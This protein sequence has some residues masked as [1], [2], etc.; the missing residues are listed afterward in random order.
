MKYLKIILALLVCSLIDHLSFAAETTPHGYDPDNFCS[1]GAKKRVEFL[2]NLTKSDADKI[3]ALKNNINELKA[4]KKI[5]DDLKSIR[6][7]YI[8]SFESISSAK[9]IAATI[10][11]EKA[12][13]IDKFKQ[14]L[15]TN[16][17]LNAIS[18]IAKDNGLGMS[19]PQT[20]DSLCDPLIHKDNSSLQ[21]CQRYGN[22]STS[23]MTEMI[24]QTLANFAEAMSQIPDKSSVAVD[25]NKILNSI[26][27]ELDPDAV[28]EVLSS[29]S[30][31]L[32]TMTENADS[33]AQ[34][35]KCIT[36]GIIFSNDSD[37]EKLIADPNKRK[38]L[39][40]LLGKEVINVQESFVQRMSTQATQ[41]T[42]DDDKFAQKMVSVKEQ[43][44]SQN[45]KDLSGL[46]HSFDNPLEN[47][48]ES[49]KALLNEKTDQVIAYSEKLFKQKNPDS[50]ATIKN[51]FSSIGLPDS[52]YESLTTVCKIPA[53]VK[54]DDLKMR[55]DV[56]HNKVDVLMKQADT[57]A[58]DLDDQSA[59]LTKELDQLLNHNPAL[60][61]KEGV[62]RFVINRYLRECPQAA[63]NKDELTS[64]INKICNNLSNVN[65]NPSDKVDA[66][67]SNMA[68]TLGLIQRGNVTSGTTRQDLSGT[69]SKDELKEYSSYCENMSQAP[70]G[71]IAKICQ[72]INQSYSAALKT[73]NTKDWEQFN[74]DYWVEYNPKAKNGEYDVYY[75]K[76]NLRIF[77]E[78]LSQSVN[79][80]YPMWFGN[81]QLSNQI[82][83]MTNQ[84]L[85]QKQLNYMYTPNSPWMNLPYFQ[86]S[87][88]P[89]SNFN[90]SNPFLSTNGFNFSK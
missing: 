26:P 24:N 71:E 66:L 34:L 90:N 28:L 39:G 56:C 58:K 57:T 81:F 7:D 73:K 86:G 22:K 5:I 31:T 59:R 29:K 27:K 30:N 61:M 41:L 67:A 80:I 37:C 48:D 51:G 8:N 64:N 25:V 12:K 1:T 6:T 11:N 75:K 69:F 38:F 17:A 42:Q 40:D 3:E 35:T 44:L 33:R 82:D 60:Q 63:G 74:K 10:K 87:Y 9:D 45:S 15:K 76:S 16:L 18:L 53:D 65:S 54:G 83:F 88:F 89:T 50:N 77:G 84:A 20:I 72:E 2:N 19:V 85:Y 36:N 49:N 46:L 78:G 21:I 4:K 23:K 14:L 13:T 79:R 32:L 55:M 62:K 47:R 43:I 68:R 52:E 70:T